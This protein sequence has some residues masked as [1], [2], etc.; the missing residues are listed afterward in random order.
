MFPV[1]WQLAVVTNLAI[2]HNTLNLDVLEVIENC[3]GRVSILN[4]TADMLEFI[5]EEL[6]IQ[7]GNRNV[8]S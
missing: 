5:D 1:P 4:V 6:A 8:K 3:F 7:Q 2:K